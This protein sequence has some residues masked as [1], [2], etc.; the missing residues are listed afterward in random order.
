M[1]S[2]YND[3]IRNKLIELLRNELLVLQTKAK[4]FQKEIVSKIGVSWQTFGSFET[5]KREMS[6]TVFLALIASFQ[7]NDS[8]RQMSENIEGLSFLGGMLPSS[9]LKKNDVNQL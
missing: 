3:E 5:G 7:N 4:V 9:D 1:N 8:T 6:W 2:E